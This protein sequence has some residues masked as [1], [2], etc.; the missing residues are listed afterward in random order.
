VVMKTQRLPRLVEQLTIS[1]EETAGG[2]QLRID[3]ENTR[4]TVPFVLGP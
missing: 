1:I 3:W 2:G 4:A